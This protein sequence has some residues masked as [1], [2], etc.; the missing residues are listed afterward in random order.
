V[1]KKNDGKVSSL[2]E[3][4]AIQVWR[5]RLQRSMDKR[6]AWNNAIVE[7][8]M[9]AY[10]H[11]AHPCRLGTNAWH[12]DDVVVL[13]RKTF[14]SIRAGL[15]TLLYSAPKASLS[16]NRPILATVTTEQG[17]QQ[18][19]ISH[20]RAEA[21]ELWLNHHFQQSKGAR[22]ARYAILEMYLALGVVK[23]G[24]RP[25]FADDETRGVLETNELGEISIG[26]N[27]DPVL[28][29]GE[30][31]RDDDTGEILRDE[32]GVPIPHPGTL[33]GEEFFVQKVDWDKMLFDADGKED[34]SLHRY[35]AEE[36]DRSWLEVRSDPRFK[37]SVREQIQPTHEADNIDGDSR[38]LDIRSNRTGVSD[39]GAVG[40]DSKR[41]RGFDIYDFVE[42]RYMV[43]ADSSGDKRNSNDAFLLDGPTP[44]GIFHGPYVVGKFNETPG[45][46]Y[47][48][49]DAEGMVDA[50]ANYNLAQSQVAV[51]GNHAKTR[52]LHDETT[53]GDEGGDI[54]K[55][56]MQDGPD[57]C[58]IQ[59]ANGAQNTL[60]EAPRGS[61][62]GSFFAR[63]P[64]QAN[65][66]NEI[67]GG[68]ASIE[69]TDTATQAN[70]LASGAEVRNS[71]RRDNLVQEFLA[72]I[73]LKLLQSGKANA[74]LTTYA[75]IKRPDDPD[76]PW[77]FRAIEPSQ[78]QQGD[79]DVDI[80][81][82]STLRHND[83]RLAQQI[84]QFL[85][86]AGQA[87]G[88]LLAT[89][90]TETILDSMNLDPKMS[91]SLRDAAKVMMEA[92]Q[93]GG[94]GAGGDGQSQVGQ[95]AQVPGG[96]GLT[97]APAN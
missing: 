72:D 74:D 80:A 11:G 5:A 53:F 40:Q 84:L 22:Q 65:D 32:G 23:V 27:G 47:P 33:I 76:Q 83:P 41:V 54:E 14:S 56:K 66:F 64:Q 20:I 17:E 58:L 97:G 45:K 42:D 60:I 18:I 13:S 43:M 1:A 39:T 51:H 2:P 15:P 89:D 92:Q 75:K 19:D 91:Q 29:S 26:P 25:T 71:D 44:P 69:A 36:W 82:G 9:D 48:V 93:K 85:Q 79:F 63:I 62:D 7:P 24:Y 77:D 55:E 37:K 52:Y 3:D 10:E 35:V 94:A 87:P 68:Q 78:L 21:Q 8:N 96:G 67:A 49:T 57:H 46:F 90:I 61:M 86:I 95:V 70:I 12:E 38:G 50:E 6:D 59:V 16:P 34:Y 28:A 4:E 81:V 73:F 31:L 88:V 30:W